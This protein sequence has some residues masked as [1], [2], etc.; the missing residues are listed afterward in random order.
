MVEMVIH[1]DGYGDNSLQIVMVA[2]DSKHF[3]FLVQNKSGQSCF[4]RDANTPHYFNT[5][6]EAVEAFNIVEDYERSDE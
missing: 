6:V 1:D 2:I 3:K 5:V 4:M